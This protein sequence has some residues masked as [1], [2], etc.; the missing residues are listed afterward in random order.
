[1][2]DVIEIYKAMQKFAFQSVLVTLGTHLINSQIIP[3]LFFLN[4]LLLGISICVRTP[5]H[6]PYLYFCVYSCKNGLGVRPYFAQG[7]G[8]RKIKAMAVHVWGLGLDIFG[9]FCLLKLFFFSFKNCWIINYCWMLYTNSRI[10]YCL[11]WMLLNRYLCKQ[12]YQ[13][14]HSMLH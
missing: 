6:P 2:S 3:I 10:K 1:M 5:S 12:T 13:A 7:F 14:F 8:R 11:L 9:S 4:L